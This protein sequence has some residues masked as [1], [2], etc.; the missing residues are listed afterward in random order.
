MGKPSAQKRREDREKAAGLAQELAALHTMTTTELAA[1]FEEVC[2]RPSRSRN[3]THL[4]RRVAWQIQAA[5]EGGL[6]A[7]AEAKIAELAPLAEALWRKGATR[8]ARPRG[9]RTP[10]RA[11]HQRDPRLPAP[12]TVLRRQYRGT[13]HAV[14]VFEDGF[15]FGGERY[16]SLSR[17]A[18]VIT[19]TPWSG[20]VFFGLAERRAT[21]PARPRRQS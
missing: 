17:V 16:R 3:K 4:R 1:K 6:S 19:G 11:G 2:G 15:E 7:A 14:T 20:P 5:A 18:R 9:G 10:A 8:A 21:S 13:A 12:G